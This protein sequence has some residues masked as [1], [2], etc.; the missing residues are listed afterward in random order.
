MNK[1]HRCL[2]FFMAIWMVLAAVIPAAAAGSGDEA[3]KAARY[4]VVRIVTTFEQ[5]LYDSEGNYVATYV[6]YSSGSGFGVGTAGQETDVFATNRHV[7]TCDDGW[8]VNN[9]RKY[10][11]EYTITGTYILLD[12]YAY[13]TK[14]Y[15]VDTS[16]AVPCTVIYLGQ[17]DDADV[18]ILRAAEPVPGRVALP[19]LDDEESLDITDKVNSLGYPGTSDKATSEGYLL[20]DIDGMVVNPGAVSRFYDSASVAGDNSGII[21]GHLIQ[22]TATI[23][24]GNSGGPLV[25]AN[26]AVVGLNTY[27]V[28]QNVNTGDVNS[29]Y[30]IRVKYAKDGLDS[31]GIKY[32]VYAPKSGGSMVWIAAVIIAVVVLAAVIVVVVKN[33]K[34]A[35]GAGKTN[36]AGGTAPSAGS[37][38]AQRAFI[39]SLAVQHNGLALVVGSTPILVGRDPANCKLIY[40]EG[41]TGVSGRHCSISYDASKGEFIITDLRSTYG[42]FLMGGQK[43]NANVPYRM[44]PGDSFYVGDKAN[45]IRVELG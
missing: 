15:T 36:A 14:S 38:T 44:K 43:L 3:V 2:T 6:G 29:Y 32:D 12:N 35:S 25:D 4:G 33:K 39:R 40:T 16:R 45:V 10:Y 27:G 17:T 37:V 18:A 28:G 34:T 23:N 22:H 20:A 31:L 9:G 30:S 42:T 8:I 21:N 11:V 5:D 1:K 26:G 13:N 19:L 7:V 41:T 24:H